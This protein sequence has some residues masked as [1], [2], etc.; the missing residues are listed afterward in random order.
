MNFALCMVVLC[1]A[2]E[3]FRP[4]ILIAAKNPHSPRADSS[5]RS[6]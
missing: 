5:L 3:T 4:V 1:Q 6:E 2:Y